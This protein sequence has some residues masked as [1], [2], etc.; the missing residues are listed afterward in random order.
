LIA[1][2]GLGADVF[3]DPADLGKSFA[4]GRNFGTKLWNIGRFLLMNVGEEAVR[5]FSE[6]TSEQLTRADA[7]ILDRL[8]VAIRECD[9]AVGPMAPTGAAWRDDERTV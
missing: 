6:L 7:W 4:T 5:P 8:D 1:G 9:R 2:M 3:L